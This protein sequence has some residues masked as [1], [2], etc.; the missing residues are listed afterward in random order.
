MLMYRSLSRRAAAATVAATAALVLAACGG[1]GS[2]DEAQSLSPK[3][4]ASASAEA[5][6]HNAQDIA[7]AQGMIP[8]HR[9]AIEMS[10]MASGHASSP[11]VRHLAERIKKAQGPE[12]NTMSGWLTAWGE[13]VPRGMPG[14]NG[15]GR[16]WDHSVPPGM[17]G[18]MGRKD[19]EKLKK[20]SG[21]DFDAMFLTMMIEHHKGAVKMATTEKAKGKYGPAKKLADDIGT[22]QSAEITEM[23]KLLGNG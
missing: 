13:D 20:F 5:G 4:P 19:V 21:Q 6:T 22:S 18:M 14:M 7:F 10:E 23:N 16:D 2:D 12:I 8:H 11:K 17:P 1:G 15:T 3:P 9:Q